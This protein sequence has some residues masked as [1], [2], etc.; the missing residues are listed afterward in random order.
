MRN[1]HTMQYAPGATGMYGNDAVLRRVIELSNWDVVSE[2]FIQKARA[3]A[4][5]ASQ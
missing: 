2:S 1:R 3:D 4:V 5:R